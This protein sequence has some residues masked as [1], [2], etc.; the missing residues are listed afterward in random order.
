LKGAEGGQDQKK[1]G[2]P[3]SLSYRSLQTKQFIVG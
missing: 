3:Q 1:V 2:P